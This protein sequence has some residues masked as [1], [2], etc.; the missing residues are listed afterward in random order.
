MPGTTDSR[1]LP[2]LEEASGKR[3]GADFG[4]GMNP[5]F[6]SEGEA[7]HDFLFPDRLV[8][9]GIDDAQH[10]RARAAVRAVPG[11]AAASHEH[12]HGR[13]DQVRAATRCWRR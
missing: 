10:R 11:R 8:L 7:V 12:A 4:V 6:L 5:E 1:V 2:A 3:A 13:D 9:G